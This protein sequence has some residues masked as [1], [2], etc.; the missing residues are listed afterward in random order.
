VAFDLLEWNGFG[1]RSDLIYMLKAAVLKLPQG[2]KN[3]RPLGGF[4]C[5]TSKR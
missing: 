5:S 3:S 1:Q 4:G 2:D